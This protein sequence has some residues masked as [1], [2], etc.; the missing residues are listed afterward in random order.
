MYLLP[1]VLARAQAIVDDFVNEAAECLRS[2]QNLVVGGSQ[3][4]L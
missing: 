2:G 4:K 3:A 1:A